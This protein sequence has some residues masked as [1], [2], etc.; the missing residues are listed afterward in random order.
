[1]KEEG[2]AADF[3]TDVTDVK[4][5]EG[6]EEFNYDFSFASSSL[7]FLRALRVFAVR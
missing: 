2:S 3:V 4:K 7:F 5:E 1:M 6:K